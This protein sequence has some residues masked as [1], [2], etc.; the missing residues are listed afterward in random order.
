M[1]IKTKDGKYFSQLG[2]WSELI[3]VIL[4][5]IIFKTLGI[6]GV[7]IAAV[8]IYFVLPHFFKKGDSGLKK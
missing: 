7:F 2:S 3:K 1:K 8:I 4:L 5:I 6:L